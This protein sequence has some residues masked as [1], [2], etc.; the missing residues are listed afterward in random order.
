[1]NEFASEKHSALTWLWFRKNAGIN[2]KP[3]LFNLLPVQLIWD[4]QPTIISQAD[5][6]PVLGR[7]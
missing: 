6:I 2:N 4:D 7:S 3:I 1:V 5:K